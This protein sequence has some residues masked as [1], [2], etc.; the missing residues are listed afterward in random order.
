MGSLI[1]L[2]FLS[3]RATAAPTDVAFLE[4]IAAGRFREVLEE[5]PLRGDRS[6][7]VEAEKDHPQA[8][9]LQDALTSV[10][11]ERGYTVLSGV[12]GGWDYRLSFRVVDIG[13]WY[14]TPG[15]F[16]R[17]GVLRRGRV[18]AFL[19]LSDPS[20]VVYWAGWLEG[21][22]EDTV[23]EPEGNPSL[24]R[25]VLTDRGRWLE[26]ILVLGLLAGLVSLSL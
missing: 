21:T 7:M 18:S 13:L 6:L 3:I 4:D 2:L 15:K 26:G 19:R 24:P 25:E 14:R 17:K 5:M 12:E 23:P 16:W 9:V 11:L 8:W 20:G 10:L 1:I 22:G